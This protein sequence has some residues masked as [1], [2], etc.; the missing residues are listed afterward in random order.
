M[1][2]RILLLVALLGLFGFAISLVVRTPVAVAAQAET[3]YRQ[4]N[5]P[6]SSNAMPDL[7]IDSLTIDPAS[8]SAGQP[9]TITVVV[10]NQGDA[11]TVNG[12]HLALYVEPSD[13]PPTSTTVD[14]A[15]TTY[16]LPLPVNG[17]F[18]YT[19]T[20]QILATS[21]PKIYAWV[22]KEN[23]VSE[24]DETNNLL[25]KTLSSGGGDDAYEEDDT[26]PTARDI[27]TDGVEQDH[28]LNRNPGADVDWVKFTGVSGVT[29]FAEAIAVGAD[30]DLTIELHST[31]D[32][33]P[34]F[35][36]GAK[37][38]FTAP[39]NGIYYLKV[40]HNQIQYGPNTA[41]K[42]KIGTDSGCSN[43][44][45]PNDTCTLSGD[46]VL[47]TPQSHAFCR[48]GDVDWL[49]FP[50]D[51]GATYKITATNNG[52]KADGHLHDL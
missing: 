40:V 6:Q 37:I 39:A 36:N 7:V 31:C 51:A 47:G 30:A 3:S 8:P 46:L 45:E 16:G 11:A 26:C 38:E 10:K 12:F 28:N 14:T 5:A 33:A 27:T 19:R 43:A 21:T 35:G 4:A 29:Y 42:L 24:S 9:V 13:N 52:A 44:Y 34:S 25:Q 23:L 32:G 2:R 20:G 18:K 41:Y 50:V 22:D 17:T 49:H 48:A 15:H 1:L